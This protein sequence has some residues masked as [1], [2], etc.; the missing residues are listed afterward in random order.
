MALSPPPLFLPELWLKENRPERDVTIKP[1]T[2]GPKKVKVVMTTTT[3]K[4]T[5]NERVVFIQAWWRG[6]LVRRTLLHLALR[7]RV[8]QCWWKQQLAILLE[9]KRRVALVLYAQ[10]EWAVV[11]LQSWVRM[12]RI[13][14]RFCR[15][16]H[17]VHI[18][19]AYWRWHSCHTRGLIQGHYDLKENQLNL[20]LEI[21]LGSQACKVQQCIPF[22]IKE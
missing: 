4:T 3:R 13:R 8:I 14:L 5:E 22:P 9:R 19:Q 17:A 12:W 10:E 20:Q 11:K 16:L 18:I 2:M 15:L 1:L 7:V 6:T 21:T